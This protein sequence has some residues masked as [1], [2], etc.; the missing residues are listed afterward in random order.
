MGRLVQ[1]AV[2][3]F[4]AEE[5]LLLENVTAV[6]FFPSPGD[7]GVWRGGGGQYDA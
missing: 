7:G 4:L 2:V 6:K 3:G 5:S 1:N